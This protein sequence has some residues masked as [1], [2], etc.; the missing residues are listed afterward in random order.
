MN[1]LDRWT[2]WLSLK[3]G[4]L[5]AVATTSLITLSNVEFSDKIMETEISEQTLP[6]P[7]KEIE[8]ITT[9]VSPPAKKQR[10]AKQIEWSQQLGKRSQ[11]FKT[12]KTTIYDLYNRRNCNQ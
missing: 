3:M 5:M 9:T 8:M 1:E 12:T 6:K 7:Q 10:S 11:E 2:G 4:A